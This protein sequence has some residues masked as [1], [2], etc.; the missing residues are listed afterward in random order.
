MKGD[1]A[2]EDWTFRIAAAQEEVTRATEMMRTIAHDAHGE[3]SNETNIPMMIIMWND[4]PVN[5]PFRTKQEATTF[6][7]MD[8]E[9]WKK[10]KFFV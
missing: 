3:I 6:L 9:L 7:G 2:L 1:P 10:Y 8:N 4:G 5:N